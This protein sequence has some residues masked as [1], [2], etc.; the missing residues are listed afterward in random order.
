[1]KRILLATIV[2]LVWINGFTALAVSEEEKKLTE[3]GDI[4]ICVDPD[5]YPYEKINAQG[6]YVGISADFLHLIEERLGIR[7]QLVPTQDWSES[8]Q[9]SKEGSCD[10]LSFLNKTDERSKWLEFSDP[11]FVDPTVI[12]SHVQHDYISDLTHLDQEVVVLPRDT[13]IEE[14]L[15]K[16]FPNLEVLLVENEEE[17][18]EYV[19]AGKADMTIR[20]L[21]MAAYVIKEKALFNLKIA[22]EIKGYDNLF[23]I[24]VRKEHEF[25]VPILNKAIASIT[26]EESI[27]ITNRHISV[28]IQKGFDYR[29][30][31]WIFSAFMVILLLVF[32]WNTKLQ[33]YNNQLDEQQKELERVSDEA[34]KNEVFYRSILIASPDAIISTDVKGVIQLVSPKAIELVGIQ[35]TSE[36]IGRNITEFIQEDEQER[37]MKNVSDIFSMKKNGPNR[38]HG[39]KANGESFV[40]EVN[41]E[42]IHNEKVEELQIVSVIRDITERVFIEESLQ[43]S[44]E[45]FRLLSKELAQKN[46]I[47][48]NTIIHDQ[49]TGVHNRYYFEQRIHEELAASDRYGYPLSMAIIDLDFFKKVNDEFG[50]SVGDE[51]LIQLAQLVQEQVRKSDVFARWGGEEFVILMPN[52][53]VN[54]A[55]HASEKICDW[56]ANAIFS[57]GIKITIS[58]GVAQRNQREYLDSWFRKCDRALYFAKKNGRNQVAVSE[59][60]KESGFTFFQWQKEWIS[61]NQKIDIEHMQLLDIGNRL[62]DAVIEKELHPESDYEKV[63]HLFRELITHIEGHFLNEENILREIAYP[64]Y[65]KHKAI[66]VNLASVAKER[67]KKVFDHTLSPKEAVEFI[68]G[69]IVIGHLLHD[70]LKFFPYLKVEVKEFEN[71]EG[72][73][74]TI[75]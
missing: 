8:I 27:Q 55:K 39:R 75:L 71:D 73:R 66:H 19:S 58:I 14:R 54:G 65:E 57:Q 69:D 48:T 72:K 68:L 64:D 60:S 29:T 12:I 46:K 24:G 50:H 17:A 15:R 5:W 23:R 4:K 47:L 25:L 59:N 61:G 38:Y 20:S 67:E 21:T 40:M 74:N 28:E 3:F 42:L 52:T 16:D 35:E 45:K 33:K 51:I 49:L 62:L 56:I 6:E 70:D 7:F 37:L 63:H 2:L 10:A 31:Y 18:L 41:S 36:L 32:V 30:F 34:H 11:Y 44:E 1:M 53:D 22:G 13:S 43:K 26:P 9:K